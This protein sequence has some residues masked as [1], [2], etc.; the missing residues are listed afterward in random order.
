MQPDQIAAFLD[1]CETRSF[2][3]TADRLG[4]T[5]STVSARLKALEQALGV[6]LFTRS[7][8]GTELTSEG[9]RFAPHARALRAEWTAALRAAG[10]AGD[11]ALTVRLGIQP[12][13]VGNRLAD[14]VA[15]F[16]AALP[17]A[18][19]YVELDYSAQM[20]ADLI[21]GALDF[22]VM[23]TPRPHPDLHFVA[24][25]ELRYRMV[26]THAARLAEVDR[27]R[28]LQG[29]FAPAF[30]MAH[31]RALPELTDAA[32]TLGQSAAVADLLAGGEGTGYVTDQMAAALVEGG[33][34]RQVADAPLLTQP[35]HAGMALRLRAARM[36]QRL[37]AI[38]REE[39]Q[40]RRG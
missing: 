14:W 16:R 2:H 35:V 36:Q 17:G 38:T 24:L 21:A 12:D 40:P 27:D 31:R 1:L 25:G 15:R 5:Q 26:S 6:T 4:V 29:N 23:F 18:A 32:I 22:A 7:R 28:Y 3:R 10:G 39:F 30:A 20:C 33:T 37:L 19:L 34:V 11:R 13:L 8:A 9:L